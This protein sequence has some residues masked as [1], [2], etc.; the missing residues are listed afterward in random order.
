MAVGGV[1]FSCFQR[2]GRERGQATGMGEVGRSWGSGRL[3]GWGHVPK[4][5]SQQRR[6]PPVLMELA[7]ITETEPQFH[8]LGSVHKPAPL[9]S[10]P[11]CVVPKQGCLR[12]YQNLPQGRRSPAT[13]V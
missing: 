1:C 9:G 6:K 13:D 12:M 5:C 4:A 2:G 7:C 8:P 10:V 11:G 3:H